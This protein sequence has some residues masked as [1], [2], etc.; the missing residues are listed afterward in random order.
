MI[1]YPKGVAGRI[2]EVDMPN[3]LPDEFK[4]GHEN[5]ISW[6]EEQLN[7]SLNNKQDEF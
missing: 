7:N 2:I 1:F 5:Y 4:E 6:Q 3:I